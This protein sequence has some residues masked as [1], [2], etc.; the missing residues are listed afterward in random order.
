MRRAP[1]LAPLI[2]A[3]G[4]SIIL[5]NAVFLWRND[6][7]AFPLVFPQIQIPIGEVQ[8]SLVQVV[9]LS[10]SLTL[11]VLLWLFV[12]KTRLGQ[13]MRACSQDREAAE[14]MGIP[15]NKIISMTFFI[16]PV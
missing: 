4:I 7:L 3:I 5:Q 10:S 8:V 9:I 15:V 2:S 1:R 11:M 14:L 6:F 16:G 13:A 12:N